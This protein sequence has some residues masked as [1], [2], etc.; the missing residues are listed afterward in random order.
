MAGKRKQ[1]AQQW[2]RLGG[3]DY[4]Y[5]QTWPTQAG[6]RRAAVAERKKGYLVRVVPNYG[7]FR[8]YVR[9]KAAR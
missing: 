2:L 6:A 9:V 1:H 5:Y 3:K 4:R 8:L 7:R